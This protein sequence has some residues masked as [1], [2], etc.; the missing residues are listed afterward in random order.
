MYNR[1]I[2]FICL[3]ILLLFLVGCQ[4]SEIEC[5]C[6]YCQGREIY[7]VNCRHCRERIEVCFESIDAT[8]VDFVINDDLSISWTLPQ[9]YDFFL[10]QDI[11]VAKDYYILMDDGT[12]V[13]WRGGT[14]FERIGTFLRSAHLVQYLVISYPQQP[15]YIII[16]LYT[17]NSN[18]Y[19]DMSNI[20][21]VIEGEEVTPGVYIPFEE[22][23]QGVK[24]MTLAEGRYFQEGAY[25][26][27][28]SYRSYQT[29]V[30]GLSD[31]E[32]R[33]AIFKVN[34][35]TEMICNV[36]DRKF[37]LYGGTFLYDMR[38]QEIFITGNANDG[39]ILISTPKS[40]RS[41]LIEQNLDY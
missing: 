37:I 14:D 17:L 10:N 35:N 16:T 15:R 39:F 5:D 38:I 25:Y 1:K 2:V 3:C 24:T 41:F 6:D 4:D 34:E 13:G 22:R 19:I 28:T 20:R 26:L 40:Q 8:P 33:T 18:F 11:R 12:Q 36:Y 32:S 29:C 27:I 23:W 21:V 30:C 31:Q 7:L 9:E